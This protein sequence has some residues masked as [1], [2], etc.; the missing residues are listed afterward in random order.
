MTWK[1]AIRG[2]HRPPGGGVP[3]HRRGRCRW[4]RRGGW[5][6]RRRHTQIAEEVHLA[7]AG[8]EEQSAAIGLHQH[9]PLPRAQGEEIEEGQVTLPP[10]R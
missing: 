6:R 4:R 1:G 5:G 2:D 10:R 8:G 7:W 3:G 9:Q